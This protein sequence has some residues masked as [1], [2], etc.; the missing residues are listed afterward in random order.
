MSGIKASRLLQPYLQPESKTNLI[1]CF[2]LFLYYKKYFKGSDNMIYKP[3][4]V[5]PHNTAIDASEDNSFS[6]IFN[7]DH[8][9]GYDFVFYDALLIQSNYKLL[10][11]LLIA[12][13][14]K[15]FSDI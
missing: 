13:T 6:F 4:N 5:Y 8:L 2:A 15:Y 3:Q 1:V 10:L 11:N 7:G 9:R 12:L 14:G